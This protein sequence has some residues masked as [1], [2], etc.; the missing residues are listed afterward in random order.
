MKT[1]IFA[2]EP[3]YDTPALLA[4]L[5]A[6]RDDWLLSPAELEALVGASERSLHSRLRSGEPILPGHVETSIR[7]LDEIARSARA[8]LAG[9]GPAEWVRTPSA[10]LLGRTP[11]DVMAVEPGGARCIRDRLRDEC[12]EAT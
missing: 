10:A 1:T 3:L 9:H 7:L 4:S 11:L 8:L 5:A 2:A 6:L 12:S